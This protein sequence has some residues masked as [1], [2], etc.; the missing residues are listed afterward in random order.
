MIYHYIFTRWNKLL[1]GSSVYNYE[2]VSDPD[3]W[4]RDRHQRFKKYCYASVMKQTCMDFVWLLYFDEKTPDQHMKPYIGNPN[5]RIVFQYPMTHLQNAQNKFKSGDIIITSRLDSDDALAPHYIQIVQQLALSEHQPMPFII[6]A[7]GVQYD[8]AKDKFYHVSYDTA[9]SPFLSLVEKVGDDA[10]KTC[11]YISHPQMPTKF[12]SV[13]VN[14]VL[15]C[16]VI[17]GYNV[18]NS[19]HGKAITE[20]YDFWSK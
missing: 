13:I 17:H 4:M 3:L 20:R 9:R 12:P 15:W 8:E 14:D 10:L 6:D 1:P 7:E 2:K 18:V 19:I 5:I 16:Q 11:F